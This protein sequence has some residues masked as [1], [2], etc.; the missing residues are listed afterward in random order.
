MTR[1]APDP[2]VYRLS[3]S[4]PHLQTHLAAL[5]ALLGTVPPFK[6]VP[7]AAF[8][9]LPAVAVAYWCKLR[10]LWQ[11]TTQELVDFVKQQIAGRSALEIGAGRSSLGRA[12]GIRQTDSHMVGQHKHVKQLYAR[13][14]ENTQPLPAWVE[15]LSAEKAVAKYKPQ[16]VVGS[17]IS[18]L[19]DES[20]AISSPYGVNETALIAQ[21]TCYIMIGN[22]HTHGSKLALALPHQALTESWLISRSIQ[23][24]EN[25]IYVWGH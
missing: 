5:D 12:L 1:R 15:S 2:S 14:G 17:W 21:V 18:Q 10:G 13:I 19:G 8:A 25:V 9:T 20:V 3:T 6:V 11:I 22:A 16:V 7:A 24:Q 23:P 4:I